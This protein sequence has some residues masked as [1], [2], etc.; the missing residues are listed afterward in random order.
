MLSWKDVTASL[1]KFRAVFIEEDCSN[2]KGHFENS[3]F[4]GCLFKRL[5][6]L[7]LKDCDLNRCRF[8]TD[9][10]KDALGFTITLDCHSFKGVSFSPLLFDLMLFLLSIS[11]DN[12]AK[13]SELVR[14]IGV[15]RAAA[16]SRLLNKVDN[17]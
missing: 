16:F 4:F 9:S 6:G 10:V 8:S 3:L 15:D 7:T 1:R 17:V 12:D 5:N 11:T 14:I 2:F 13:R